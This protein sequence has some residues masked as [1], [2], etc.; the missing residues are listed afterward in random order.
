MGSVYKA[1]HPNYAEPVALKVA[2]DAVAEEITLSRRFQ[3]E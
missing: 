1:R 3:N 2:H